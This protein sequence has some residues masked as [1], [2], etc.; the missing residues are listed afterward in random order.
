MD[1]IRL[2]ECKVLLKRIREL[3]E[4]AKELAFQ[5]CKLK[6]YF[7]FHGP[8]D[9]SYFNNADIT[10]DENFIHLSWDDGHCSGCSETEYLEIPIHYLFDENWQKEVKV[11]MEEEKIRLEEKK[12]E[13][14]VEEALKKEEREKAEYE[15][16]KRKF[17]ER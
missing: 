8:D 9:S 13:K 4:Q 1:T 7:W 10:F 3:K 11:R 14:E 2:D 6:G 15:R 16:L 5:Y 12:K 17:E